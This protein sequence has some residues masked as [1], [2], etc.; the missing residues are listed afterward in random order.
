MGGSTAAV[1]RNF[2]AQ[3]GLGATTDQH[4]ICTFDLD[5]KTVTNVEFRDGFTQ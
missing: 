2:T 4:Y 5:G 1:F 3:N